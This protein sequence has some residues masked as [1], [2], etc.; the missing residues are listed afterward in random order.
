MPPF[1]ESFFG[2]VSSLYI[3]YRISRNSGAA[4][5]EEILKRLM[6]RGACE[7]IRTVKVALAGNPNVGKST[8]FNSLTGMHVHTGNWAGKT[9]GCEAGEIEYRGRR[10]LLTDIPGSYSLAYHSDEERIARDFICFGG[11]E[12]TVAVCDASAL[13]QNLNLVLQICETGERVVLAINFAIEAERQGVLIDA[14]RLSMLLGIPVLKIRAN[15]RRGLDCL[16]DAVIECQEHTPL[17]NV[18]PKYPEKIENAIEKLSSALRKI[19]RISTRVDISERKLRWIALRLLEGDCELDRAIYSYLELSEDEAQRVDRISLDVREWLFLCGIDSELYREILVTSLVSEA[20]RIALSV[21]ES[22]KESEAVKMSRTDK[23]L[24]GRIT[25]YPTMLLLVA[26]VFWI[27]LS[28]ANYPSELLGLLFA[29]AEEMLHTLFEAISVPKFIT[30]ALLDG[31]FR[32]LGRVVAVMLPPMAIFFPLFS[33]LE[34]SGYLPRIAYNLDRPFAFAGACGKQALTM[35]MGL[36]CNAVG[37]VGC[38]IIDSKRE[39]LLALLTNSLVPCNGRLPMLITL[40]SVI[41]LFLGG[42]SGGVLVALMLTALILLSVIATFFVTYILSRTL[43]RGERSAF[44]IELPK[45]RK[46]E[47]VKVVFRSLSDKCVSIL[48]RAVTVAAPMG[49]FIWVAANTRIGE[50]S[51]LSYASDFL[52]PVGRFFGMDGVILLAFIIGI[53]ANEIVIPLMLMMYTADGALGAEIG[54]SSIATILSGAGWSAVTVIC[55][56]LFALFHWPCSTSL[57]TVYKETKSARLL[58]LAFLIPTV[59]GLLLCLAVSLVSR[60][61][62]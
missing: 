57:I 51:M 50:V 39:R 48:M 2:R 11:S 62:I 60:L 15:K 25:A 24:T 45:Y 1:N 61:F 52:D 27:T 31:V 28:L 38:R 19:D 13:M 4:G 53:P 40:I 9:V 58:L 14:E 54:I 16:L 21:T 12:V 8:L 47:V 6:G 17:A 44:T 7:E 23:F 3:R 10:L 41:C 46:P 43:F 29:R 59:L 22:V 35:C 56:T 37:I 49:L 55:T 34:D 20:E 26:L 33:L 32:T 5:G 36:G 42:T 18:L 30:G